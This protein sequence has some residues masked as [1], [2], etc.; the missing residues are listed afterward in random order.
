[1]QIGNTQNFTLA[2]FHA[3]L[4]PTSHYCLIFMVSLLPYTPVNLAGSVILPGGSEI[5]S[6]T[7][8]RNDTQLPPL[9]GVT[10]LGPVPLTQE[11]MY[12][13]KML[14]VAFRH[15]PQPSDSEKVRYAI[16]FLFVCNEC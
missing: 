3:F 12:Q 11:K 13:L 7:V 5:S 4:L 9:L 16:D 14:D 10:P 6:A 1:M 2:S 15:L 8:P